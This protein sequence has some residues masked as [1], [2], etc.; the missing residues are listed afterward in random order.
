[1]IEIVQPPI[2]SSD[3]PLLRQKRREY[4][5][6]YSWAIPCVS[7][8]ETIRKYAPLIEIGAG[9]GYW[10]QLISQDGTEVVLVDNGAAKIQKRWCETILSGDAG[11]LK[12]YPK[13]TL[14]LCWPPY[15]S[16]MARECLE[17]YQGD[18]F[19]HVGEADGGCTADDHFFDL[20]QKNFLVV[21]TVNIPTWPLMH[22]KLWVYRRR[23]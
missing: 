5:R 16:S 11:I 3:D 1:M 13:H 14:F 15:N 18:Y 2:I 17:Q 12:F 7:A 19:I 10:G 8:I 6:D 22:D 9:G 4:I 23:V 20:L 21:E